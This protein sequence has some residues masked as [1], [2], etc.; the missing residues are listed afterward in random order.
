MKRIVFSILL[1]F[2]TSLT[3]SKEVKV[4]VKINNQTSDTAK[5]YIEYSENVGS[6]NVFNVFSQ[7]IPAGDDF[8]KEVKIEKYSIISGYA[9]LSKGG[10]TKTS[11]R[12]ISRKNDRFNYIISL[13]NNE[14]KVLTDLTSTN[15]ILEYN[16]SLFINSDKTP[17]PINGLFANYLGGVQ[18]YT[19]GDDNK[20]EYLSTISPTDLKIAMNPSKAQTGSGQS[21]KEISFINQVDQNIKGNIPLAGQLG[22][23]FDNSSLYSIKMEYK[24]IG[25]IDYIAEPSN[26]SLS[27]AFFSLGKR[28]LYNIGFLKIQ[29]P[30]MKIRQINQ[31]YVF[32]GIFIEVK[33]GSQIKGNNN[34]K[35]ST[36]FTNSGNFNISKNSL[37]KKIY[38]SSYLGYWFDNSS[39]NITGSL[40]YAVAVYYSVS[41][42]TYKYKNEQDALKE[43]NKLRESNPNFPR[44]KNKNEIIEYFKNQIDSYKSLNPE[45][46]TDKNLSTVRLRQQDNL[47]QLSNTELLARFKELTN[48]IKIPSENLNLNEKKVLLKSLEI[49]Q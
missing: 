35:A 19:V 13:E 7:E 20:I 17:K 33:K 9:I 18:C 26:K 11:Y 47:N 43:Y 36:F 44:L 49:K 8:E 16:P 6:D 21:S 23:T 40:D 41:K 3:Y 39:Q 29:N 31:A 32:D 14:T 4:I 46:S 34:I 24:N 37:D 10:K 22:V 42:D 48:N 15:K 1:G 30:K 5:V 38:G 45:K 2:V 12:L 25:V 28:D 27:E